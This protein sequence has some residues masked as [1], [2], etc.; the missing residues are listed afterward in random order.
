MGNA[1]AEHHEYISDRVRSETFRRAVSL[2]VEPGDTVADLGC[3][4]GVLGLMCL[5]AGASRVWGVDCTEAIEIARETMRRAG[6]AD[7]YD[8][9]R[10]STFLAEL[11][12]KVDV[13][14]CDHVGYFGFDYGIIR[15]LADARRRLIKPDGRVVPARIVLEAAAVQSAGCREKTDAWDG[16]AIPTE[17]RWLRDY[18]VNTRHPYDFDVEELA[19]RPAKLGTIDLRTDSSE[20][21]SFSATLAVDRDC[22][23]DG[24][25]GWFACEL[26]DDVWMTNSP[27]AEGRIQRSQA[28]LPFATPLPVEAGDRVEITVSARHED[29]LIAWTARVP[30]TGQ[31]VRQSTWGSTILD[32]LDRLPAAERYPRLNAVGEARRSLLALIDGNATNADIEQAMLR[33]YPGLFPS[34]EL[35]ARF[36]RSELNRSTR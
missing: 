12:E 2:A 27:L 19:S 28:F 34:P 20:K 35:M 4:F 7:R 1:L 36:V 16:D 32:P 18:A 26:A 31:S 8:C 17:F 10:E 6:F 22:E 5:Q 11:P 13:G 25:A 21:L 29:A 24:L 30:R 23:L 9:L 3:G 33:T 15:I 14:I